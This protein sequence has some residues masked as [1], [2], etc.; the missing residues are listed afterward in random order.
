[1]NS[2]IVNCLGPRPE[3]SPATARLRA[4][5]SPHG[6]ASSGWGEA[7]LYIQTEPLH[8]EPTAGLLGSG[9]SED[10]SDNRAP[11]RRYALHCLV[12]SFGLFLT[13]YVVTTAA[14]RQLILAFYKDTTYPQDYRF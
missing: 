1:M 3:P 14:R 6:H 13:L 2:H 11:T 12:S 8:A 7:P 5:T 4:D 9:H 10:P